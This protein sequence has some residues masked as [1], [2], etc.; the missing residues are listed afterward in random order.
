MKSVYLLQANGKK[1]SSKQYS[2]ML[3]KHIDG[4]LHVG[5]RVRSRHV[6]PDIL[7]LLLR[8]SPWATAMLYAEFENQF[9]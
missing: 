2:K 6:D 5:F 8:I 3:H 4:R 9:L 7:G 1:T